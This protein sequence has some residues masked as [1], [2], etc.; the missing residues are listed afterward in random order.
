VEQKTWGQCMQST[1]V[2]KIWFYNICC[3]NGIVLT[4][5]QL[6][7]MESYVNLLLDWNKKINL[8]SRKD[9]ESIWSYHILHSTAL[10]F[11]IQIP[12]GSAIVDLGTG[13]GL[14]GIPLKIV[15]PDLSILCL[16]STGKKIKAV[17]EMILDIQLK[18]INATW[19]RAEEIG[20][21]EQY[22]GKFDFVVARAVAP[23]EELVAWGKP[24]LKPNA[25]NEKSLFGKSRPMK[26]LSPSLLVFKGG[27]ISNE[28]EL[29]RRKFPNIEVDVVPLV[30]TKSEN[31]IASDKKILIVKP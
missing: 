10:L 7:R 11:L 24:F 1:D 16:D 3:E 23:L 20:L 14:P 4:D 26:I 12:W 13:G 6:S 17:S 18:N 21:D 5:A 27:D 19:G 25:N 30:F 28:L 9:E 22:T 29:A 15:R 31:L 8:I 2:K